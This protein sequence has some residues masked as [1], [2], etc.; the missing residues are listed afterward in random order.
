MDASAAALAPLLKQ[1]GLEI[2]SEVRGSS[3]HPALPDG[4]RIRIRCG[5]TAARPGDIIAIVADPP[6]VHRVVSHQRCR[7]RLYTITRGDALWFCDLPVTDDQILGIACAQQEGDAWRAPRGFERPAGPR[8]MLAWLSLRSMRAAICMSERA[9]SVVARA[10]AA[11]A[12]QRGLLASR[13]SVQAV[14]VLAR[15]EPHIAANSVK[16]NHGRP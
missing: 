2:E 3:M 13:R 11:L 7:S 16:R 15:P 4:S 14:A 9:A 10:G 1:S 6:V 5:S 8:S 12:S